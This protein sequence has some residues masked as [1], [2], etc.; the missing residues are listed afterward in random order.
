VITSH[1]PQCSD[2]SIAACLT[3]AQLDSVILVTASSDHVT[4]AT[5]QWLQHRGLCGHWRSWTQWFWLRQAVITSHKPQCSDH[6]TAVCVTLAQLDSV[7][8]V[9]A[10]GDHVTQAA[11]QWLQHHGLCD[12]GTAGLSDSS[13]SKQ[14]SRHTSHN[15]VITALRLVWHWYSWT[16]L[17]QAVITS[18]KP[19]CSDYSITVCVQLVS[20]IL[21]TFCCMRLWKDNTRVSVWCAGR[22]AG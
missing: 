10:S 20:V 15:A 8:L 4:Q 19:Q 9:T 1:K 6:S 3:L 2:Y 7:I 17:Q 12:I 18:H 21:V 13:Y 14:W 11:M 22:A 16:Q 5:M